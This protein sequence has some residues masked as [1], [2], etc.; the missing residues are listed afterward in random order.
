MRRTAAPD[1]SRRRRA[2][3]AVAL[4]LLVVPAWSGCGAD[5][6]AAPTPTAPPATTAPADEDTLRRAAA[7]RYDALRDVTDRTLA[8]MVARIARARAAQDLPVLAEAT[9][10]YAR[11]CRTVRGRLVRIR[12]PITALDPAAAV[13]NG[14][15]AT[16]NLAD[17]LSLAAR[18]GRAP[19][20]RQAAR[21]AAL[22]ER[23]AR[24]DRRLRRALG[25]TG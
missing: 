25:L 5:D 14:L 11:R 20:A 17:D 18:A 1:T 3:L 7:V 19:T 10:A 23:Q 9:A 6:G 22:V 8:A 13:A 4:A 24:T 16:S 21:L 12:M 2:P 15:A